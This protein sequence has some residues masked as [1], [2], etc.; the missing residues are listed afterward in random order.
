M[1]LVSAK[2]SVMSWRPSPAISKVTPWI[3]CALSSVLAPTICRSVWLPDPA[4]RV[5]HLVVD[6]CGEPRLLTVQGLL[7]AVI[8]LLSQVNLF[9]SSLIRLR[10]RSGAKFAVASTSN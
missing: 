5:G 2:V 10:R 8:D 3:Q 9:P 7:N 4:K 1:P 6:C